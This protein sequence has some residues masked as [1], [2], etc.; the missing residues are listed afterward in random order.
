MTRG[1]W[2]KIEVGARVHLRYAI[3]VRD[4]YEPPLSGEVTANR[5]LDAGSSSASW[6]VTVRLDDGR[7]LKDARVC[8]W[9]VEGVET[10]E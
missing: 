9:D 5:Y 8:C 4:R 1:V 7:V 6:G 2:D 3:G 10:Q